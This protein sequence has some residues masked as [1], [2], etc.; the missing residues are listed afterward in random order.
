MTFTAILAPRDSG[1]MKRQQPA[2]EELSVARNNAAKLLAFVYIQDIFWFLASRLNLNH[3]LYYN[4]APFESSR[5]ALLVLDAVGLSVFGWILL[6]FMRPLPS[7]PISRPALNGWVWMAI[8]GNL[9]FLYYVRQNARYTSGG[10]T[11]LAGIIY[12]VSRGLTLSCMVLVIRL[13]AKGETPSTLLVGALVFVFALTIDGFSSALFGIM[14]LVIYLPL[15]ASLTRRIMIWCLIVIIGG[16][17]GYLA[18]IAKFEGIPHAFLSAETIH[19]WI[20]PRFA[21]QAESMYSFV[22]GRLK[23]DDPW[24]TIELISRSIYSRLD[25]LAGIPFHL[26]YPRS[27]SESIYHDMYG[28]FGAGSSPGALLGSVMF[29]PYLF[30]VMPAIFGFL[31]LQMF[32]GASMQVGFL[33][34]L[35]FSFLIKGLC[36]DS[37]EYFTIVSPTLVYVVL[38]LLGCLFRPKTSLR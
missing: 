37:S 8:V 23:I 33:Q 28:G 12:G 5:F 4:I 14:F 10:L 1:I 3:T 29:G 9:L 11:G 22:S 36:A 18:L 13:K 2:S 7:W 19:R 35:A 31:F 27:V 34:L 38:F 15:H 6:R 17:L 20:I 30:W 16:T 26:E 21:V 24:V 25:I 32:Y